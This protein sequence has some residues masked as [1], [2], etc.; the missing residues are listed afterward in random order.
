MWRAFH[1]APA[2]SVGETASGASPRFARWRLTN[3][4]TLA[5]GAASGSAQPAPGRQSPTGAAAAGA[6]TTAGRQAAAMSAA[7]CERARR[8]SM[9]R[10]PSV[11][12]RGVGRHGLPCPFALGEPTG[13]TAR[14]AGYTKAGPD[15]L[16]TSAGHLQP[17]AGVAEE[18]SEGRPPD[19]HPCVAT[20]LLPSRG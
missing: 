1:T 12:R 15:P 3:S 6:A 10:L 4:T 13:L 11:G 16:G 2:L 20:Q 19:T 18:A 14:P 5:A 17:R 8:S 9:K 7:T